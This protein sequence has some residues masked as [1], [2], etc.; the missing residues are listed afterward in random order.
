LARKLKALIE[1]R[2]AKYEKNPENVKTWEEVKEKFNKKYGYD[3]QIL[4]DAQQDILTG[5]RINQ[6]F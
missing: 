2:L 1:E 5:M 3:L 4:F 6:L